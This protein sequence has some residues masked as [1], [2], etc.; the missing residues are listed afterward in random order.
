MNEEEKLVLA[1]NKTKILRKP[2][3]ALATFGVTTI[4]YYLLS[5]PAYAEKI[6]LK[7]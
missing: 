5:H 4:N 3:Q 7:Q 6:R 1:I 2:Q